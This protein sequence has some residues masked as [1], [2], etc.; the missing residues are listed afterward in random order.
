MKTVTAQELK[1]LDPRRFERE[2]SKWAE[3][4][5]QDDWIIDDVQSRFTELYKP[6]GIEIEELHYCISY[7]QGDFASFSGR[8]FL[9]EWMD[10]TP[11]CKDGPTYAE[12]YPALYIACN[13]DGSYLRIKGEDN[14][15]GWRVDFEEAW[16]S[17]GPTGIFANM[18]DEDWESLVTDQAYEADLEKEIR[19]YCQSIGR[20]IYRELSDYFLDATSEDAFMEWCEADSVTFE[21]EIEE[22][23]D[24]A[25]CEN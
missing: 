20:E 17:I 21:V 18:P 16:H 14:R 6:K 10:A 5:W 9:A 12:R 25:C 22:D 24:E 15:R 8:V 4:Q 19:E 1:Q 3:W 11:V 7:S 2:F 13:E 23:E